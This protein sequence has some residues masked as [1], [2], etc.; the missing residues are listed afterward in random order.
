[1]TLEEPA[2]VGMA[3]QLRKQ[4][5]K[6][7]LP[8]EECVL[9]RIRETIGSQAPETGGALGM[10]ED[11]GTIVA[12]DFDDAALRSGATYSPDVGRLN[13]VLRPILWKPCGIKFCGFVHS[14]PGRLGRPSGG[15]EIYAR[16]ILGGMTSIDRLVM[17]IVLPSRGGVGWH[18][19]PFV[20]RIAGGELEVLEAEFVP[21]RTHRYV[22]SMADRYKTDGMSLR[23]LERHML[24]LLKSRETLTHEQADRDGGQASD[25]A[26]AEKPTT[27]LPNTQDRPSAGD[28]LP[29]EVVVADTI[30]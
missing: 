27:T 2:E 10:D 5:A 20:A 3:G 11:T 21:V 8:I 12:F 19:N 18:C 15:D 24:G 13:K 14:H 6:I 4:P 25:S 29:P 26:L 23:T 16:N 1:M 30:A 7:S 28:S 17:P 22:L 9:E